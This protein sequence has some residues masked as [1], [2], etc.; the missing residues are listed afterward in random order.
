[1]GQFASC[2]YDLVDALRKLAPRLK[3]VHLKDIQAR[4]GEVNVLLG[5]GICRIPEVMRELHRQSFRGLV[6]VE[7][8]R[9][10]PVEDDLRHEVEFARKLAG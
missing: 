6:A 2:G 10:G 1:V 4:D 7:Y 8:E 3:L 5:T 9:E